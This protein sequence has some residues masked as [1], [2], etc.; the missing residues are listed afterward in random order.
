MGVVLLTVEP[1]EHVSRHARVERSQ[2]RLALDR[3]LHA[4]QTPSASQGWAGLRAEN[5]SPGH[6]TDQ[7]QLLVDR[8]Q[9]RFKISVLFNDSTGENS[10]AVISLSETHRPLHD[11]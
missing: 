7:G 11:I 8:R 6:T 5:E 3:L 4:L 2:R 1:E 10:R 9:R